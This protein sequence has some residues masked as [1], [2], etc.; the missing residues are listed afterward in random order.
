MFRKSRHNLYTPVWQ[1]KDAYSLVQF[2]Q[3][4]V[5]AGLEDEWDLEVYE[6]L[7]QTGGGKERMTTYFS[8]CLSP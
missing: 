5:I 6:R 7:L 8:V 1:Q 4:A 3:K 2:Q